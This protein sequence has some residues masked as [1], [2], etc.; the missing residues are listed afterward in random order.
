MKILYV[1]SNAV[2]AKSL[3]ADL[4]VTEL[5]RLIYIIISEPRFRELV[6]GQEGAPFEIAGS[7]GTLLAGPII[8]HRWPTSDP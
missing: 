5:R 3:L 6:M 8:A 2:G 1:S 4:E 7:L